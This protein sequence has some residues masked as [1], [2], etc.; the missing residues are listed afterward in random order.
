MQI[1][2]Q[3]I[4]GTTPKDFAPFLIVNLC[5]DLLL[6]FLY[7]PLMARAPLFPKTCSAHCWGQRLQQTFGGFHQHHRSGKT[8][9][10]QGWLT[11]LKNF[12]TTAVWKTCKMGSCCQSHW[13]VLGYGTGGATAN[14]ILVPTLSGSQLRMSPDHQQQYWMLWLLKRHTDLL[15]SL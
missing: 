10:L 15:W 4:P 9:L 14:Q 7:G 1:Q 8:S 13:W 12:L 2:S 5:S 11:S 6:G 3:V